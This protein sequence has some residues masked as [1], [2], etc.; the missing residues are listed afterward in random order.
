MAAF[1][2]PSMRPALLQSTLALLLTFG[3]ATAD[4]PQAGVPFNFEAIP[5]YEQGGAI[6]TPRVISR[7]EPQTSQAFRDKHK[8][9]EAGVEAVVS[10]EGRVVAVRFV[11]GDREWAE[12]L[13][14]AVAR[15]RFEPATLEGKP[16][17]VRF[18]VTST[19]RR[20]L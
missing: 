11:S 5:K 14:Q 19:F 16:I 6:S 8:F 2:I 9:A 17:M 7:A 1:M 4:A 15:W 18:T 20:T 12:L 10:E 3:C 13:A